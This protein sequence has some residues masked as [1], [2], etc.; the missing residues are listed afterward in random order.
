MAFLFHVKKHIDTSEVRAHCALMC[1]RFNA[2]TQKP[3]SYIIAHLN[4]IGGMFPRKEKEKSESENERDQER[5]KE[6]N[7]EREKETQRREKERN[8][9]RECT[10]YPAGAAV[11]R[12]LLFA[13]GVRFAL[14]VVSRL[15]LFA[16]SAVSRLPFSRFRRRFAFLA[17]SR[18]VKKS[19][20]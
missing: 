18:W 1:V 15:P 19:A 5:K 8:R 4:V 3:I 6:R 13:L 2:L 14:A 20:F 11:L 17:V 10:G 16:F 9:E 7:K 12:R